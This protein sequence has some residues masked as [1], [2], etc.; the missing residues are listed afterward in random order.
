M[1]CNAADPPGDFLFSAM[2]SCAIILFALPIQFILGFIFDSV[3]FLKPDWSALWLFNKPVDGDDD[4]DEISNFVKDGE[5][6]VEFSLVLRKGPLGLGFIFSQDLKAGTS[7]V[8]DI[9]PNLQ[10]VKSFGDRNL[11]IDD[12]VVAVNGDRIDGWTTAKIVQQLSKIQVNSTVKLTVKRSRLDDDN[13]LENVEVGL[14]DEGDALV[15]AEDAD[16]DAQHKESIHGEKLKKFKPKHKRHGHHR[17]AGSIIVKTPVVTYILCHIILLDIGMHWTQ[18]LRRASS[19]PT[20]IISEVAHRNNCSYFLCYLLI[21]FI[22]KLNA[23]A[24]KIANRIAML[25]ADEADEKAWLS[26]T[27]D[28]AVG[29]MTLDQEVD[30]IYDG[31]VAILSRE[32]THHHHRFSLRKTSDKDDEY[33]R[34]RGLHAQIPSIHVQVSMYYT[35]CIYSQLAL[36][37]L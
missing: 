8:T 36:L 26:T 33:K 17:T 23:G 18:Y 37:Y 6:F 5:K 25:A 13:L 15:L 27:G 30:Y 31:A 20:Y 9:L 28:Q 10:I 21:N 32:T 24:V 19:L 12:C 2:I 11:K 34:R 14:D 22:I 3:L 16:D 1:K 29:G 4:D 35:L 7:H